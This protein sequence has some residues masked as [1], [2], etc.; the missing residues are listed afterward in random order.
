MPEGPSQKGEMTNVG[1]NA[2][3]LIEKAFES[4]GGLEFEP[5]Q[6][7]EEWRGICLDLLAN[8]Q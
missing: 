6:A 3:N 5:V 8:P 2:S 7:I 1:F 4:I